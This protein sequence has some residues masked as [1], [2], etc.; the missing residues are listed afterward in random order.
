MGNY[1]YA[2]TALIYEG[3]LM[4]EDKKCFGNWDELKEEIDFFMQTYWK[5]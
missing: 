1:N 4:Y 3:Q 2:E 5:V